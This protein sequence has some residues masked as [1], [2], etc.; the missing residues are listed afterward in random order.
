MKH[1][2][3]LILT[4]VAASAMSMLPISAQTITEADLGIITE[5]P[6]GTIR[7]YQRSGQSI[8]DNGEGSLVTSKQEGQMAIV[9]ADDGT[10]YIEDPISGYTWN[11]WVKAQLS[12]DGKQITLPMGQY[13]DLLRTFQMATEIAVLNY[14]EDHNT[15]LLDESVKEVV[16]TIDGD[17]ISLLGTTE[18]HIL[19]TIYRPFND[20][21][22]LDGVWQGV[23][24]FESVYTPFSEQMVTPPEDIDFDAYT[25]STSLFGGV[26]W[27]SF[28]TTVSLATDGDDVYLQG[29]TTYAPKAWIKGHRNGDNIVFPSGQFMGI[30]NGA[31]LYAVGGKP[32]NGEIVLSDITFHD[33]GNG[34]LSSTDYIFITTEKD[35]FV[36]IVYYLGT[37]ISNTIDRPIVAPEGL[38]IADY[39]LAYRYHDQQT[40]RMADGTRFVKAGFAGNEVYVRGLW[41]E[42]PEAWVKGTI[43]GST[44]TF[45]TPQYL[46]EVDNGYDIVYPFYLIAFNTGDGHLDSKITLSYD[47]QTRIFTT[48]E[49]TA[50]STSTAMGISINKTSFLAVQE[51]YDPHFAPFNE[52]AATPKNPTFMEFSLDEEAESDYAI[53]SIPATD[54]AGELLLP[55]KLFYRFYTDTEHVVEPFTLTAGLYERL[56]EDMTEIPYLFTD[57]DEGYD[58]SIVD[59]DKRKVF[60]NGL[61]EEV[62][63]IGV[64]SIYTGAGEQRHSEIAWHTLREYTGIEEVNVNNNGNV[65]YYDLHGRKIN[66]E[67]HHGI[68]IRQTTDAAGRTKTEKI[69]R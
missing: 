49:G 43:D 17:R 25:L 54:N 61:S 38:E 14:D 35:Q 39:T 30:T 21:Q 22:E 7:Y 18:E 3:N 5:Q 37:T 59:A 55:E 50:H 28:S 63:R 33:D 36:Y 45:A 1:L 40:G 2:L 67:G 44:V 41:S 19:G 34:T 20:F 23:G 12:D 26:D 9:F 51:Y 52:K 47:P 42:L 65:N 48:R 16:Y 10:V 53:V 64:E 60:L 57:S 62:N 56:S 24:D 68:I 27:E 8:T 69:L 6:A 4:A 31:A 11:R 32:Q 58:I 13:I 15:Y 29:I 66:G 46:G